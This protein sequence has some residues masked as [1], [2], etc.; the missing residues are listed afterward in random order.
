MSVVDGALAVLLIKRQGEPYKGRWA[1]PGGVL[2]IDLVG[3]LDAGAQRVAQERLGL[4]LPY[5]RQQLAVGGPQRDPRSPWALSVVY[6]ALAPL[7]TVDATPGKR[8]DEI[9]WVPADKIGTMKS[10]AFD[11]AGLIGQAAEAL[12][13]E[14]E[15]L[16]LPVCFVP[17]TFTLSELQGLCE[18]ILGHALD[19]VTFRRR[20][21]QREL[22]LPLAGEMR[23]GAAHRPAQIYRLAGP[24]MSA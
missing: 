22:V 8:V 21:M 24:G 11:H 17:P 1:L 12:R 10:M 19:K 7:E 20:I 3:S 13:A 14:V 15:E 2:R 4:T 5:L 6:R 16:Q 18:S 23:V 9:R